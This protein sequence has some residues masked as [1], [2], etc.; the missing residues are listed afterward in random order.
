MMAAVPSDARGRRLTIFIGEHDRYQH[1]SLADAILR[2]ARQEGLAGATVMRGIEGFGSGR[3]LKTT[4]L[5]S[6]S[7]DLPI[8]IEMIDEAD[9]IEG[10]LPILDA[11]IERGLVVLEVVDMQVGRP[12]GS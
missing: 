1:H 5:L 10:F 12:G 7:D 2:R 4:R 8:V 6:S 3:R 11:M 9:R